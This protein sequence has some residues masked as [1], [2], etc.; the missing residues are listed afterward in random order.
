MILVKEIPELPVMQFL[1]ISP[2][3]PKHLQLSQIEHT[4]FKNISRNKMVIL[5]RA[6]KLQTTLNCCS[7][8][9]DINPIY[10]CR[11]IKMEDKV[12]LT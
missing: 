2:S 3:I 12:I 11:E 1:G 6:V 5:I 10:S 7:E 4:T 8:T 9:D